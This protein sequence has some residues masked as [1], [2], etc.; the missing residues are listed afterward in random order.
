M[1]LAID[2]GKDKCGLAVLDE[3]GG[4]ASRS[5]VPRG[6]LAG[7]LAPLLAA[8]RPTAIVIGRSAFGKAVEKELGRLDVQA[9]LV[10]ASEK[11]TT[12]QARERYWRDN[13]P[14]GWRKII[15]TSLL[16]PPVPVDDLAAVIIGERYLAS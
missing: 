1:I 5:V 11:D 9:N 3:N 7:R 14:R 12:W 16:V 4:V 6:E 10:F 13:P 8:Y 15:P 2:P